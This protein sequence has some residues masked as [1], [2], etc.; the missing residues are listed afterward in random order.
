M[1]P[2]AKILVFAATNSTKSI[3]KGLARHAGDV[4][5]SELATNIDIEVI[6]LNDYE[7]PIYSPERE[8]QGIPQL[9]QDF[10]AKIGASDGLI[11]SLAEYNGSYTAAFKNIF[12]WT[13]RIKMQIFQDK[14]V[15]VMATSMGG[16]GGQNVL[17]AAMG[18]FPHFGANITSSF[19]FGPFS[20]HF[21]IDTGQL[22]TP[23]LAS[24]LR[25]ALHLFNAVLPVS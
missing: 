11:V 6:D 12:D 25:K 3:N 8:A 4:L 19:N 9:A 20:E 18:G 23:G 10:Y 5:Q 14:P 24:D 16:R 21:D 15:L 7:M 2:R 1:S 22:K 13:S 17:S